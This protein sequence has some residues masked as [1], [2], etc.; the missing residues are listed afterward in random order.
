[1]MGSEK[2]GVRI[3]PEQDSGDRNQRAQGWSTPGLA[4]SREG[5]RFV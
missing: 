1:M 2:L 5:P 4:G 3:R